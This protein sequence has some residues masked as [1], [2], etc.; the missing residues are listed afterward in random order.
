LNGDY[1][2][3]FFDFALMASTYDGSTESWLILKDIADTWLNCGLTN[4][5][6]CWQ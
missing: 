2:V 4:Q 6:N 5:D 3:D 1:R